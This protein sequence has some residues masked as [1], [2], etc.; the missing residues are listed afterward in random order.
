MTRGGKV[1]KIGMIVLLPVFLQA[2]ASNRN[3]KREVKAV[4]VKYE[5]TENVY[6]TDDAIR[7][8]LFSTNEPSV[9]LND[10]DLFHLEKRLNEHVMIEK[11]EVFFTIDGE[12][13]A[14]VKQRQPIGRIND[15]GKYYYI[16]TQ[17]KRMPL[18]ASYSARVPLVVGNINDDN[19]GDVY[20]LL[21]FIGDDE[22]LTKNITEVKIDGKN[23]YEL[24]MRIPNFKVIL[25]KAEDLSIKKANLKA[26]YRKMEKSNTLN[27]Y[28][29]VNLKYANQVVCTM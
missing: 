13:E 9:K 4:N 21:Q 18:S 17:G 15:K 6:V 3:D 24:L 12:L 26:F 1:F 16:D 11:S 2:F 10:L 23:E 14:K 7:K 19:W 8:L 28:K 25:G 27:R 29:T 5:G 20:A 22:F